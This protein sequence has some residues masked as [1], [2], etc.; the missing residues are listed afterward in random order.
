MGGG[1]LA[2][3]PRGL[4]RNPFP[5]DTSAEAWRCLYSAA[6][7]RGGA[8]TLR[9]MPVA[10]AVVGN[11]RV[12]AVFAARDMAAERRRAAARDGRHHLQLVEAD[13]PGIGSAP[14]EAVVAENIRDLQRWTGHG[15]RPLR[16]RLADFLNLVAKEGI[17]DDER[18]AVRRDAYQRANSIL[19]A[20]KAKVEAVAER[21][22]EHAK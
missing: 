2:Y 10:A 12:G 13:V 9:A 18:D 21:L 15:R 16:R 7:G 5:P 19:H 14:S 3:C 11:D 1:E 8:L 17:P 6:S 4:F 22:M 20:H